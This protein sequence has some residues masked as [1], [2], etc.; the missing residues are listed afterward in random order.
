MPNP[1]DIPL[2]V[3]A[4]ANSDQE[5]R[6]LLN[7]KKERQTITGYLNPSKVFGL[8]EVIDEGETS[9]KDFFRMINENNNRERITMLHF[10]G[11]ADDGAL[12]L[13]SD[14]HVTEVVSVDELA[15]FLKDLPNLRLVF[16]NGCMTKAFKDKLLE[17]CSAM[18]IA[19]KRPVRDSVA[20]RFSREFYKSFAQ[21]YF[22]VGKAFEWAKREVEDWL[23]Q[24]TLPQMAKSYRYIDFGYDEEVEEDSFDWELFCREGAEHEKDWK[25]LASR[26]EKIAD[27]ESQLKE[28]ETEL[29][30]KS[31]SRE[32]LIEE[33]RI[34]YQDNAA[35]LAMLDNDPETVMT[36]A[37][38]QP[39]TG[40]PETEAIRQK[41]RT[42]EDKISRLR[43]TNTVQ[44]L[45]SNLG[46][47]NFFD[48]RD[49]AA[50]NLNERLKM[51]YVRGARGDGQ[52]LL[53]RILQKL[54]GLYGEIKQA[55][56]V[57]FAQRAHAIDPPPTEQNIWTLTSGAL[58]TG[59]DNNMISVCGKITQILE[60]QHIILNWENFHECL[61]FARNK[62]IE[63]FWNGLKDHVAFPANDR[64]ILIFLVENAEQREQLLPEPVK[65]LSLEPIPALVTNPLLLLPEISLVK[66]DDLD[67]WFQ[68]LKI[69]EEFGETTLTEIHKPLDDQ[70][71]TY[72]DRWTQKPV[73]YV[74]TDIFKVFAKSPAPA[75]L[76]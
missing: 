67:R 51:I 75:E 25:L 24:A 65:N 31:K 30:G 18:V 63:T 14:R 70:G 5:E 36:I 58:G 11:H 73:E 42:L 19:T 46:R 34:K 52:K 32:E 45:K 62:I 26:E 44:I 7:L 72:L 59:E 8:C 48:Q 12:A 41:I 15:E 17:N 69:G 6:F 38:V 74:I 54:A 3:V 49:Q 50:G 39:G 47:F 66:K 22:S 35:I 61:P 23:K 1:H 53:R 64:R 60:T 56:Q 37:G 29:K 9:M 43:V 27:L 76:I 16:L 57:D 4:C 55:S 21:S 20:L 71:T 28:L 13:I 10:S 2:I 68:D 33:L 40:G